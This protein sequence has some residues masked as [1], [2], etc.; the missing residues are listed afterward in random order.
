MTTRPKTRRRTW[1]SWRRA[2]SKTLASPILTP[3]GR[4][5]SLADARFDAAAAF[6][7]H[8]PGSPR[9]PRLGMAALCAR[10]CGGCGNDARLGAVSRLAAAVPHV[11][12]VGMAHRRLGG[13]ALW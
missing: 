12:G 11:P 4:V 1:R 2:S 7:D 6:S 8:S 13:G 3:Q 9:H 5:L 10:L